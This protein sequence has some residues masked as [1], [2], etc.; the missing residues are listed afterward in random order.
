V[1]A[2]RRN[3]WRRGGFDLKSGE[4]L[5]FDLTPWRWVRRERERGGGKL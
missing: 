5:R 4:R 1:C 2:G 3:F